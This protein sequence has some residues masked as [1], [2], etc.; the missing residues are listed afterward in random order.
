MLKA[1]PIKY[2][3][4]F[5]LQVIECLMETARSAADNTRHLCPVSDGQLLSEPVI[6]RSCEES[7]DVNS[8]LVTC[9]SFGTDNIVDTSQASVNIDYVGKLNNIVAVDIL[10][11]EKKSN[12]CAALTDLES[13]SCAEATV[14][15]CLSSS[16]SN[17]C[18]QAEERLAS[19]RDQFEGR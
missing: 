18:I 10:S 17:D 12:S 19:C 14:S 11:S 1:A 15:Y 16:G 4:A 6:S 7:V 8:R 2:F 3:F 9:S 5:M 13:P